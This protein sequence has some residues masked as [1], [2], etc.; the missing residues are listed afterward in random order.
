MQ[1][2]IGNIKESTSYLPDDLPMPVVGICGNPER[3]TGSDRLIGLFVYAFYR[4]ARRIIGILEGG[5]PGKGLGRTAGNGWH[6]R[7][8]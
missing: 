1:L 7:N 6:G 8:T 5:I 4:P 3:A 2:K